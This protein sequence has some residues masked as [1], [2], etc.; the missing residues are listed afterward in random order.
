MC[1]IG[2]LALFSLLQDSFFY[3]YN[4]PNFEVFYIERNPFMFVRIR[5]LINHTA[6]NNIYEL[7]TIPHSHIEPFTALEAGN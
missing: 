3:C 7:S 5:R 1:R 4:T 6:N 2:F